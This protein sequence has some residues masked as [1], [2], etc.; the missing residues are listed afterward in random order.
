METLGR[1]PGQFVRRQP[2]ALQDLSSDRRVLDLRDHLHLAAAPPGRSDPP[3]MNRVGGDGSCGEA[4]AF[5]GPVVVCTRAVLYIVPMFD[6]VEVFSAT[7]Y[8]DR[9]VL[10]ERVNDWVREEDV[11]VVDVVVRQ[12]SDNAYHCLT[13]IVFY[14]HRGD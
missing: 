6:G 12:S 5:R 8:R 2:L 4:T 13:I 3:G 10:D 9:L 14:R 7:L 11:D 1:G